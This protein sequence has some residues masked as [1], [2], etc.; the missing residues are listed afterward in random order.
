MESNSKSRQRFVVHKIDAW[1]EKVRGTTSFPAWGVFNKATKEIV[2]EYDS[3]AEA[4]LV[5]R[6]LSGEST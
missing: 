4:R 1:G 2:G 3:P 5:A 6:I